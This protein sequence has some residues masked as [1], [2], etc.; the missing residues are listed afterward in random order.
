M[1]TKKVLLNVSYTTHLKYWNDSYI[2]N[3]VFTVNE[4]ESIHDVVKSALDAEYCECAKNFRPKA[5][6]F[7]DD[8]DGNTKQTGWVYS[9]KCHI[10]GKLIPFEAWVSIKNV[11][12]FDFTK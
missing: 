4:N 11:N 6:M 3:K 9:V 5:E 8:K 7:V 2:K 1:K 12:D 10:E